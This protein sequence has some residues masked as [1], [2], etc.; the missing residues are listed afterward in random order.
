[1]ESTEN[2]RSL[3][4][5]R[6]IRRKV[7]VVPYVIWKDPKTGEKKEYIFMSESYFNDYAFF[8]GSHEE[9]ADEYRRLRRSVA[10]DERDPVIGVNYPAGRKEQ[11]IA[12]AKNAARELLE[13][14]GQ[15]GLLMPPALDAASQ[16]PDYFDMAPGDM[17]GAI[18]EDSR[19]IAESRDLVR[20]CEHRWR[21]AESGFTYVWRFFFTNITE[22]LLEI[23]GSTDVLKAMDMFTKLFNDPLFSPR[24]RNEVAGAQFVPLD[25]VKKAATAEG[26]LMGLPSIWEPHAEWIRSP[27]RRSDRDPPSFCDFFDTRAQK[28]AAGALSW[29]RAPAPTQ[30]QL[31]TQSPDETWR[32]LTEAYLSLAYDVMPESALPNICDVPLDELIA[33]AAESGDSHSL[34]DDRARSAS[35]CLFNHLR[36]TG[37]MAKMTPANV[38][39]EATLRLKQIRGMRGCTSPRR[40]TLNKLAADCA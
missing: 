22:R 20:G 14:T 33:I 35:E 15:R 32:T 26:R 27:Q 3:T 13:E 2:A 21:D 29:R 18:A 6:C 1:M 36:L 23:T 30:S 38:L 24:Q 9:S 28:P 11:S 39:C 17:R 19:T 37:D 16:L 34:V 4:E 10:D 7:A 5:S 25:L 12:C 40:M 31:R 8:G